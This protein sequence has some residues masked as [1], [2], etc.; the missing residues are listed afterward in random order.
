M[1]W[2]EWSNWFCYGKWEKSGLLGKNV[3]WRFDKKRIKH[4]LAANLYPYRFCPHLKTKLAEAV[5]KHF[6]DIIVLDS[7]PNWDFHS[8]YEEV[9]GAIKVSRKERSG[10]FLLSNEFWADGVRPKG[11]IALAG[12]LT[13]AFRDLS[14]A[15]PSVTVLLK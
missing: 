12:I 5:L 1:D 2:T 14:M 10:D 4:E 8:R 9:P 6:P 11:L 13:N 15:Q 3:Q 7:D